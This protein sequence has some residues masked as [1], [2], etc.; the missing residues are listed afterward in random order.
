[1][2]W[3]QI[4][5]KI[6]PDCILD[7]KDGFKDYKTDFFFL[8]KSKNSDSNRVRPWF[9]QKF[10]IYFYSVFGPNKS[11]N[12]VD[13]SGKKRILLVRDF[14]QKLE[15]SL[16][17]FLGQISRI[18]FADIL[19]IK[20]GFQVFKVYFHHSRNIQIFSKGLVYGFGK[21]NVRFVSLFFL[22]K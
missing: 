8:P 5:P 22:A 17:L 19:G 12:I 3:D 9:G 21:T 16:G 7:R 18:L 13:V 6:S 11:K 4:N 15:I 14:G 2:F 10:Q 20:E 1:M